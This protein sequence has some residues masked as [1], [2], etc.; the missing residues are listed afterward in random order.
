MAA[1]CNF[2]VVLLDDVGMEQLQVYED[3]NQY[4]DLGDY[5]Y[6]HLPAAAQL[7]ATGM[8]FDQFRAMPLCS[9]TRASILSGR[10]PFRHGAGDLVRPESAT[11]T[12]EEFARPPAPVEF[13]L[14]TLLSQAGYRT[15]AFGKWHL[16]L[17]PADGGT[18]D[19]HPTDVGFDVWRGT[20][21]NL[22]TEPL[23]PT[24][25][26]GLTPGYYNYWWVEDGVR[27]QVLDVY[28]SVQIRQRAQDW[29]LGGP[30]PFFAWVA[31]NGVHEPVTD[32]NW[33]P[34]RR[35]VAL[36]HGFGNLP[37]DGGAPQ[38]FVNTR[39]RASLETLDTQLGVLLDRLGPVLARTYVFF[40]TDNGT[41]R[42]AYTVQPGEVRYPVGHP[43][44][45]PGD[46]TTP[47]SLVPYQASHA[48]R[49]AFDGG[50]R[51]PLIVTGPNVPAGQTTGALVDCVDLFATIA[52]LAQVTV[53]PGV[54]G[55]S[56]DF[57]GPLLGTG[58]G[59]RTFSLGQRFRPNG[60]EGDRLLQELDGYVRQDG[61]D[62]WK[63]VRTVSRDPQTP[64]MFDLAFE[65]FHVRGPSAP[66]D[67]LEAV[68][69]GMNHPEFAATRA[70][71]D[72]LL[73]S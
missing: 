51:V 70:G 55:D 49:S 57:S 7:A 19:S 65:F 32:P 62:L 67:P 15:G 56:V 9:P 50:I 13:T 73:A 54:A 8:R 66:E 20:P 36:Q 61:Q 16:G 22:D 24:A 34:D 41:F 63:L 58:A 27:T 59:T 42:A 60:F 10:Y 12:F 31:F 47:Y 40:L 69:L 5:P 30:E 45:Q 25:P 33:P 44:H 37:P 71:L 29:M 28:N 3:Q 23:P 1:P 14:P 17:E 68:D 39:F 26:G 64:G 4:P 72:A 43:L 52:S 38:P 46:E 11:R 53:P 2:L 35:A 6:P 18:M 21:R 48:K